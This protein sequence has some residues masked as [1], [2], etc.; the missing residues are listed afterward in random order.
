MIL[1]SLNF[2]EIPAESTGGSLA[3][4]Q[5]PILRYVSWIYWHSKR[6]RIKNRG[7]GKV[8]RNHLPNLVPCKIQTFP[9]WWSKTSL[10]KLT[11]EVVKIYYTQKYWQPYKDCLK[12]FK[13]VGKHSWLDYCR[14]NENTSECTTLSKILAREYSGRNFQVIPWSNIP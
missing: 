2:A 12:Q 3:S 5:K 8:I 1:A 4:Y 9:R 10:R 6:S 11:R 13:P 7:S 14:N